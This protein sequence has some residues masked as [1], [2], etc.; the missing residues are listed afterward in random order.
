MLS[1]NSPKATIEI[2][3]IH[4]YPQK[5]G[6]ADLQNIFKQNSQFHKTEDGSRCDQRGVD[7]AGTQL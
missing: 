2:P 4:T 1:E 5:L 6:A 3:E 7:T